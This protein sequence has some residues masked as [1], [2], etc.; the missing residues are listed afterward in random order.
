MM[1]KIIHVL[2]CCAVSAGMAVAQNKTIS[3]RVVSADDNEPVAGATIIVKGTSIGTVTSFDGE[4]TLPVPVSATT[5]SVSFVG[6]VMQEVPIAQDVTIRLSADERVLGEVVVTALGISKEKKALGYAVQDVKSEQLTQGANTSLTGAL[7]GKVS[8]VDFSPT[9]GMPGASAKMVIRGS[10]SFTGDNTPLYVVDGMPVAS[11]SDRGTGDSVSGTDNAN[12]SFDVDP[13][14]IESINILK[15][16]AASALYGMRASN[17]VVIITTKSGKNA[18]KGKAQISFSTSFSSDQIARSP[19]VQT[20]YAQGSAGRYA[21]AG[22]AS[23][24][25]LISELPNDPAY[26]GNN[27]GYPGKYYVQQLAQAYGLTRDDADAWATPGSYD[28]IG[29]FFQTGYVWNNSLNVQKATD[30]GHYSFSL[31]NATQEGIVPATGMERYNAKMAAETS[32]G[33][34]FTTGF[35]GNFVY[36]RIDKQQGANDGIVSSVFLS[37][38]SYNFKG[39]PSYAWGDPYT[40]V[41][42]RTVS[43][44]GNP[45]WI[46]EYCSYFEKN[47]RFFGNAYLDYKTGLGTTNQS[48]DVKYILGVDAY[49]TNY[50]DMNAYGFR[51]GRGSVDMRGYTKMTLNS[52]LTAAYDWKISDDLAFDA[53]LGNEIIHSTNKNYTQSGT[54]FNFKGWNHM[55]NASVHTNSESYTQR[56]TV[57][58]FA[59]LSLS[60]RSMLYLNVTGRNDVVSTMPRGNRSFFYPSA[61]T[62]FIFTEIEALKNN[63]VTFGKLR[64]SYAEVGMAG[65]YYPDYYGK[66][67]YGGGFISGITIQYPIDG[68]M[69]Y[70]KSSTVYN[71]SLKPQNTRSYEGGLDLTF[72]N[73]LLSLGYTYSRQNVTDQIFSIPLARSTGVASY[74]TNGGRVHTDAHEVSLGASP[75]NRKNIK[76]DL[77]FNFS[78]IDNYVDELA[79]GVN[80]IFLGGY[81]SPNVRAM[82]GEKYPIVYGAGYKKDAGGNIVI[83]ADGM[84]VAGSEGIIARTAADFT[85]G[86]NTSLYAYGFRLSATFDWRSG[87]QIM[88]GT[89]GELDL[90]GVSRESGD[91]RDRGYALSTGVVQ[92]GTDANGDPVYSGLQTIRIPA[93]KIEEYYSTRAAI[94]ESRVSDNDFVKL[95]EVALSYPLV[96]NSVMEINANIF[97]RNLLLWSKVKN[98]DPET[99]QG[100]NN[101]AGTFERFSLP[102]TSSYG[103][104]FN[105]KF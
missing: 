17:G 74:Y 26:G 61:S 33:E 96:K 58:F 11:T 41:S 36:S 76:W 68:Q 31:G 28:N 82:K 57:G 65:E 62:S 9:S 32:L 14:D 80:N 4:F 99:S 101:M 25:P 47:Q 48:L 8:G 50:T 103:V 78:K 85:L 30:G 6:M 37:P 44:W 89:N 70:H 2:L 42:Y 81:T 79:E 20:R 51:D 21:P 52:L 55:N 84:P 5:L 59:N 91:D 86:F 92:T 43:R 73:G 22:Q 56:R 10:R 63:V 23:W 94:W 97:A 72:F 67:S 38:P 93:D 29:D 34:H 1:K 49:Q 95:R 83:T 18:R 100:N 39:I 27:F 69:G 87:G 3:G 71:P 15:G 77:A 40:Q 7:Q 60:W 54:D 46:S 53:L 105:L 35:T 13:N 75:L 16:Q 12:R 45:Y 88:A 66:G 64:L 19:D 24:G 90:Y 104:G 102:Q 98:I